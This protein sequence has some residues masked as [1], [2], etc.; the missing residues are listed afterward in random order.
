ML[1]DEDNT[2]T[3]FTLEQG[4]DECLNK[5]V[6]L[7]RLLDRSMT[8]Y[9]QEDFYKYISNFCQPNLL[10][11]FSHRLGSPAPILKANPSAIIKVKS[12]QNSASCSLKG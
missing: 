9:H 4:I 8:N 3:K 7:H 10:L 1:E 2:I 11:V 5:I 12:Y 6:N